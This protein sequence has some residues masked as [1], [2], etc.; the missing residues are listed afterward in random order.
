VSS[1]RNTLGKKSYVGL[2]ECEESSSNELDVP[3]R[4]PLAT[5][6]EIPAG[7]CY[8]NNRKGLVQV[9]GCMPFPSLEYRRIDVLVNYTKSDLSV[10]QHINYL[11]ICIHAIWLYVQGMS[12]PSLLYR[13]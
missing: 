8:E 3:L 12:I 2:N 10:G 4:N 5:G 1:T 9:G 7:T 13:N 11:H 6:A